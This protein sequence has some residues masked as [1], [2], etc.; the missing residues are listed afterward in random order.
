[1]ITLVD[2]VPRSETDKCDGKNLNAMEV[3]LRSFAA[4]ARQPSPVAFARCIARPISSDSSRFRSSVRA[5]RS[6]VRIDDTREAAC[7]SR[8]RA[9]S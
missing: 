4:S 1:V 9:L 8:D 3:R 7:L 2:G 5:I 6:T